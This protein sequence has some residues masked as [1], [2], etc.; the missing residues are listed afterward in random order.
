LEC[1]RCIDRLSGFESRFPWRVQ[2]N[3]NGNATNTSANALV[4]KVDVQLSGTPLSLLLLQRC[5]SAITNYISTFFNAERLKYRIAEKDLLPHIS[6][7]SF[8]L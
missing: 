4:E 2:S 3:V 1:S 8:S 6:S 5:D 7:V